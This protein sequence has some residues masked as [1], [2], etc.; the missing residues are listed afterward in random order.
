MHPN[1]VV[2]KNP[3]RV[4]LLTK[5]DVIHLPIWGRVR[6]M[7][8]PSY[9]PASNRTLIQLNVCTQEKEIKLMCTRA[10]CFE[11]VGNIFDK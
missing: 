9:V 11:Y 8:S 4:E 2:I 1:H 5:D 3:M 6:V 10:M 7:Q